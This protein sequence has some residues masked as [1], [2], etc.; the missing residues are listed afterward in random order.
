MQRTDAVGHVGV[1]RIADDHPQVWTTVDCEAR[2][3]ELDRAQ[4]GMVQ[5]FSALPVDAHVIVRP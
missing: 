1:N 2:I 3:F 4:N 5:P